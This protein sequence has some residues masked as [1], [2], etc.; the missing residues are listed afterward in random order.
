MN[1]KIK[2]FV[3]QFQHN[4]NNFLYNSII[5]LLEKHY[6]FLTCHFDTKETDEFLHLFTHFNEITP[7]RI[8]KLFSDF[9]LL[10]SQ[11]QI[12]RDPD[13]SGGVYFIYDIHK[14]L[15]YIGK[16]Q[17]HLKTRMIESFIQKL[18][19][20]ANHIKVWC[21]Q[22]DYISRLESSSIKYYLPLLNQ[23]FEE[24]VDM[25]DPVFFKVMGEIHKRLMIQSPITIEINPFQSTTEVFDNL[26]LVI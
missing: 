11:I 13:F 1:R 23:Q 20:G 2:Q 3:S 15:L 25:P 24:I 18:P 10:K 6:E 22:D 19:Y 5:V 7:N 17:K 26:D 8:S 4:N 14:E 12:S 9:I 21:P 16:S